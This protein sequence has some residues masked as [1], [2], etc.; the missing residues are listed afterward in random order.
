MASNPHSFSNPAQV[1]EEQEAVYQL[2]L[3]GHTYREIGAALQMSQGTVANRLKAAMAER[4]DPLVDEH[5]AIELDKIAKA[6]QKLADQIENGS[7]KMLARNVE[8]FIRLS[9]RRAKL[10]GLD[11]PERKQVEVTEQ[12]PTDVLAAI[13]QAR[14]RVAEQEQQLRE[15]ASGE[16]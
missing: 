1:T 6:E 16:D 4:I 12:V 8:V 5:R 3:K 14:A 13:E 15:Q 9:E 11:A 7:P 2:V 10:L